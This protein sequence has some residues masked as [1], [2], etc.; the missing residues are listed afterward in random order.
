MP[1]QLTK[2][3]TNDLDA[4]NCSMESPSLHATAHCTLKNLKG[5]R[6]RSQ[7]TEQLVKHNESPNA[8]ETHTKPHHQSRTNP[9]PTSERSW[10]KKKNATHARLDTYLLEGPPADPG[11][12]GHAGVDAQ[13]ADRPRRP[14]A[15]AGHRR[16]RRAHPRR[17]RLP[18]R[19]LGPAP[20]ALAQPER[21]PGLLLGRLLLLLVLLLEQLRPGPRLGGGRQ[22]RRH[23]VGHPAERRAARQ[24]LVV[25]DAHAARPLGGRGP[26]GSWLGGVGRDHR[27]GRCR[28]RRHRH[29]R[30]HLAVDDGESRPGFA[31]GL[32]GAV[33]RLRIVA[34]LDGRPPP[35]APA[36]LQVR[37]DRVG[38]HRRR[39]QQLPPPTPR[40]QGNKRTARQS[41]SARA[42][43]QSGATISTPTPAKQ[44][45]RTIVFLLG[46]RSSSWLCHGWAEMRVGYVCRGT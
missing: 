10:R 19:A 21:E 4:W 34:A 9:N 5:S 11:R 25:A 38:R 35:G 39:L 24:A 40:R 7:R 36:R 42:T 43:R 32:D 23:V 37:Q 16:R 27:S 6:Q 30:R 3:C 41:R 22:R 2:Q 12:H 29:R 33:G 15:P 8:L 13:P 1:W 31:G 18:E 17:R 45:R 28:R 46:G 14:V 20:D 26:R 44:R